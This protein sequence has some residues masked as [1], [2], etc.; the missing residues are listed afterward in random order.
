MSYRSNTTAT[1]L[2][3]FRSGNPSKQKKQKSNLTFLNMCDQNKPVFDWNEPLIKHLHLSNFPYNNRTMLFYLK[4]VESIH[5][6]FSCSLVSLLEF[7]RKLNEDGF[8]M[9]LPIAPERQWSPPRATSGPIRV[10][11]W[12][13]WWFI[14]HLSFNC[15]QLIN[16]DNV[17]NSGRGI[18]T[19][20][21]LTIQQW[22]N[23]RLHYKVIILT[24]EKLAQ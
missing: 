23:T 19:A 21:L 18:I 24:R 22:S 15:W 6:V 17:L 14:L 10:R 8:K 2:F 13:L 12:Y 3:S 9:S 7:T 1:K 11:W 4:Q 16:W 5:L 20:T